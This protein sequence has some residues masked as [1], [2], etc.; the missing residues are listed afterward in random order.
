MVKKTLPCGEGSGRMVGFSGSGDGHFHKT[1]L[2]FLLGLILFSS[3]IAA[4][5]PPVAGIAHQPPG[6]F[7]RGKSLVV[8]V[9]APQ[10][11]DWLTVFWRAAGAD[12]FLAQNFTAGDAGIWQAAIDTL[13]AAADRIEYYLVW[14]SNG[15]IEYLP[16]RIPVDLFVVVAGGPAPAQEAL[17]TPEPVAEA[18]RSLFP[19]RL[20][21]SI[22]TRFSDD[23]GTVVVPDP[24]HTE[25]VRLNYRVQKSNFNLEL[26]SRASY[27]NLLVSGQS[28][29]DLPDLRLSVSAKTHALHLG[30]IAP[31]ESEMTIGGMG[32]R[33]LEYVFD[34]QRFYVHLFTGSTQQLRGF[35]G[36][37]IPQ[38]AAS[39]FGGAAGFTLFGG[40]SLKTVYITGQ[41]DPSLAANI[42]TAQFYNQK[43]KGNVMAFIGQS[44]LWKKRLTL[45]AEY[46]KSNY[47]PD[48]TD[49]KEKIPG[50]ALRV[51]GALQLG[52]F[53]LRAGYRNVG[54]D[55]NSIAQPFFLNDRKGFDVAAAVTLSTFRLSGAAAFE[56][57]NADNDP[58]RIAARDF[59]RQADVSW[60]FR[61]N[62][63][64]RFG[65][66]ASRQDARLN[67]NPVLQGNVNR[68][69]ITA[70]L[71]LG[72]SPSF[73]IGMD[74]RSDA[75]RSADNPLL[76][77]KSTGV[78]INAM[79]QVADRFQLSSVGGISRTKNTA[80]GEEATLYTLF[81]NGDV[82]LVPRLLS[83]NG[84]GSYF[85]Y[86]LSGPAASKS[87]N[88]DGGI[89]FHLKR[90][91]PLGDI[92]LSLR[93][94]Y[95]S[96][97]IAG[98]T[99][100]DSRLFLRSDISL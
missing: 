9:S 38:A 19:L 76:E 53:D 98:V 14:K 73:Q 80:S 54:A 85:R 3:S 77:G 8:K 41:D 27:S 81:L 78:N 51:G 46:A 79:W 87:V 90:F 11:P 10:A 62:S 96:T 69:G 84:T 97:A 65:Y 33:G 28:N 6:S 4:A 22:E 57:T 39:L 92:V 55:F 61:A 47:D 56:K 64:L 60:Q 32:R 43:R 21:A 24:S 44:R 23:P 2:P 20:D 58:A 7:E 17:V 48:A 75:L 29:F 66:S 74:A 13:P 45:S 50:T 37:G 99:T 52:S 5:L 1:F 83:L 16:Q 89:C 93:G 49:T 12:D 34:D 42:G 95:F 86:D 68:E 31:S 63:S 36:F 72:F 26:Q 82:T 100:H 91:L 88:V 94:G 67:N 35:K 40:L 71:A 70:G 30:D 18:A 15:Q 25:N 59:R